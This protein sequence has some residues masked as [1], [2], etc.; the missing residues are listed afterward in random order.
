MPRLE[1]ERSLLAA[2]DQYRRRQ[3]DAQASR[4]VGSFR[5]RPARTFHCAFGSVRYGAGKPGEAIDY[6]AR[7]D[8]TVKK[9]AEL[10]HVAGDVDRLRQAADSVAGAVKRKKGAQSER[11]VVKQ[12]F[13]LP[14]DASA[15]QRA[16][17][18]EAIV[19]DWESRGH[20]AIAAIHGN[21]KTLPHVHVVATAR[22][23]DADGTVDR[24]VRLWTSRAEVRA[25]RARVAAIVNA[26]C[27]PAVEF[28]PGRLEDTGIEREAKGRIPLAVWHAMEARDMAAIA[29]L[30]LAGDR[31]MEE[32]IRRRSERKQDPEEVARAREKH[33]E[34]RAAEKEKREKIRRR[35]PPAGTVLLL[36]PGEHAAI[37]RQISGV[38][39]D[40]DGRLTIHSDHPN[41]GALAE[42]VEVTGRARPR[43]AELVASAE[44]ASTRASR[45]EALSERQARFIADVHRELG[46]PVPDLATEEGRAEAFARVRAARPRRGS[47][48]TAAPKP[49]PALTP[50]RRA[51]ADAKAR[52]ASARRAALQAEARGTPE[53]RAAEAT[54][55]RARRRRPRRDDDLEI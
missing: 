24:S 1:S 53:E 34:R 43:R 38:I 11:V 3:P 52:E 7:I 16:E 31:A 21:G 49:P 9:T 32:L 33:E 14:P 13:E 18:A 50:E 37:V 41:A 55:R 51:A 10:E 39:E 2:D 20:V 5:G 54:A 29:K 45:A 40:P 19:A 35:S 23:V 27:R 4:R 22:P 17:A 36:D 12:T 28:H 46:L 44:T 25:E 47:T 26:I 30:G 42:R 6:A 15:E 48:A 8:M